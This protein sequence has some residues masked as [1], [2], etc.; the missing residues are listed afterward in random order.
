[1]QVYGVDI[2]VKISLLT[3]NFLLLTSYFPLQ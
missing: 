3:S 1:M 2:E